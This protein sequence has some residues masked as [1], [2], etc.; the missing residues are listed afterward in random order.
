M[1]TS[2]TLRRRWV[3]GGVERHHLIDPRTGTPST[4]DLALV[5]VVAGSAWM[6]EVLAKGVL[7]RGG[8]TPST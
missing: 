2:T 6:A 8:P 5:A 1:A 7:L 4:S 3:V